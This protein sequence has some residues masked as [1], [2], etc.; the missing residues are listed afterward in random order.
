MRV[1][2]V[3]QYTLKLSAAVAQAKVDIQSIRTRLGTPMLYN[4]IVDDVVALCSKG[5][6]IISNT[7]SLERKIGEPVGQTIAADPATVSSKVDECRSATHSVPKK[8]KDA[9]DELKGAIPT[10]AENPVLFDKKAYL[11]IRY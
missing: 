6:T 4:S 5:D 9:A 11:N 8:A 3:K 2:S 10:G 1:D 7:S